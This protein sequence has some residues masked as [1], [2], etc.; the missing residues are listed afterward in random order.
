MT[1]DIDY[2]FWDPGEVIVDL[3]IAISRWRVYLK[4][5][6]VWT[7]DIKFFTK[8][9]VHSLKRYINIELAEHL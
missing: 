9:T 6:C 3:W 2:M 7:T 1:E 5:F 4:H 8:L